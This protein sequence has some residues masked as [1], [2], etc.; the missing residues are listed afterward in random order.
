MN[1]VKNEDEIVI[2]QD[3]PYVFDRFISDREPNVAYRVVNFLQTNQDNSEYR[4]KTQWMRSSQQYDS[5]SILFKILQKTFAVISE[6][7]DAE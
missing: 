2:L 7:Y 1:E 6:S 5:L 4:R 3:V